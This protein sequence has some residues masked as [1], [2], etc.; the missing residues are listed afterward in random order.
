M[1]ESLTVKLSG[2]ISSSNAPQ[3]EE[4]LKKEIGAFD[5]EKETNK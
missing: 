2:R 3:V 4:E 1:S 5:Q